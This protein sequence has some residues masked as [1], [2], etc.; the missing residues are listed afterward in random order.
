MPSVDGQEEI[1]KVHADS[2]SY[3]HMKFPPIQED[4]L[5]SASPMLN[6]TVGN[7]IDFYG[8]CDYARWEKM[9]S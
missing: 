1:V 8:S 4:T 7:E 9:M 3:C 6:E 5:F 2:T